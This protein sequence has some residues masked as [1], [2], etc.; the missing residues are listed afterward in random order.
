[1]KHPY[2]GPYELS[3]LS[4]KDIYQ[5]ILCSYINLKPTKK[6]INNILS[7][8]YKN[9]TCHRSLLS[10]KDIYQKFRN[11]YFLLLIKTNSNKR[12]N[13]MSRSANVPLKKRRDPL[14]STQYHRANKI[15]WLRAQEEEGLRHPDLWPLQLTLSS[16]N[17]EL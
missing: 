2:K 3:I 17:R 16:W 11:R 4:L 7:F 9:V 8:P 14:A 13:H 6:P 12:I 5:E 1:M 10:R 15:I